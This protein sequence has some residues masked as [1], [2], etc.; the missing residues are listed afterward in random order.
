MSTTGKIYILLTATHFNKRIVYC[1]AVARRVQCAELQSYCIAPPL[2]FISIGSWC[3][4]LHWRCHGY[5]RRQVL[6]VVVNRDEYCGQSSCTNGA[7]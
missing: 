4:L 7:G 5:A 1:V 2:G 3:G 6:L